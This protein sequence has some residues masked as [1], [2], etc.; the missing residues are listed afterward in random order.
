MRC[1]IVNGAK[2][3]AETACAYCSNKIGARYVR[4]MGYRR[5][6]CD[7]DCYSAAI[8]TS[9]TALGYRAPAL[10]IWKRSS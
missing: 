6:Y 8:E 1:V 10:G 7:F 9:V 3:K 2:L 5:L 4:E